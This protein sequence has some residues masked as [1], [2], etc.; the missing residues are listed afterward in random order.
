MQS[1]WALVSSP[2]KTHALDKVRSH[3]CMICIFL[4]VCQAAG[5]DGDVWTSQAQLTPFKPIFFT[6]FSSYIYL[7]GEEGEVKSNRFCFFVVF[8]FLTKIL[9]ANLLRQGKAESWQH[10]LKHSLSL[11]VLVFS[12]GFLVHLTTSL[13][14]EMSSSERKAL[15][16]EIRG[17]RTSAHWDHMRKL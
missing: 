14:K 12:P 6:H 4:F 2:H 1:L 5:P 10:S 7:A 15:H 17:W 11:G 9:F 3:K 13:I 16:H 8:F